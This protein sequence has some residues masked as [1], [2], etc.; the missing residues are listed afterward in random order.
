MET[1]WMCNKCGEASMVGRC[2][3]END[4]TPLNLAAREEFKKHKKRV[5]EE[6]KELATKNG[7]KVKTRRK[8]ND[9]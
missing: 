2:C 4:R 9:N 6:M 1:L 5:I 3:T 8:E 7:L